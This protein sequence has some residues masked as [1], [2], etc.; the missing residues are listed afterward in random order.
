MKAKAEGTAEQHK[1]ERRRHR[2]RSMRAIGTVN[3]GRM[4]IPCIVLNL[5][6]GGAQIRLLDHSP[7]PKG[8]VTLEVRSV[9]TLTVNVAWQ[10]GEFVGM[11]FAAEMAAEP[12]AQPAAA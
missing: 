9:G 10:K 3:Y 6:R 11:K 4:L 1:D 7:L 8:P 12:P 2:R 5:S